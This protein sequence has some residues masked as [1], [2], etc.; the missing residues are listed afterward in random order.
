MQQEN[1]QQGVVRDMLNRTGSPDVPACAYVLPNNAS[2]MVLLVSTLKSIEVGTLLALASSLPPKDHAAIVLFGM[3]PVAARQYEKLSANTNSHAST[4][5]FETL[6]SGTLAYNLVQNYVQP[7]SCAIE[8]S[9]HNLPVLYINNRVAVSVHANASVTFKWD[10]AGKA[11]ASRS[12]KDLFIGWINQVEDPH[13]TRLKPLGDGVGTTEVPGLSG[14]VF[15]VLTAQP[16]LNLA[17]LTDA[18]LAGPVE[19]TIFDGRHE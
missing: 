12:G 2:E 13:Y 6:I 3:A 7:G 8:L 14:T 19:A 16:G 17:D 5:S 15:A 18:T 4:A 11:A 10:A 1:T 9:I